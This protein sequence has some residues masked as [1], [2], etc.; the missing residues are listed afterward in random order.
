[1]VN[2]YRPGDRGQGQLTLVRPITI[3]SAAAR[4][5]AKYQP[6]TVKCRDS[7]YLPRF[8]APLWDAGMAALQ[9]LPLCTVDSVRTE[10]TV[11]GKGAG[12]VQETFPL[13]NASIEGPRLSGTMH[14]K[15]YFD[16]MATPGGIGILRVRAMIETNDGAS[17][18]V[19]YEARGDITQ[20]T[21]DVS[22]YSAPVFSTASPAYLWLNLVQAV[23]RGTVTA[24][25]FHWDWYEVVEVPS[26]R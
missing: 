13:L 22:G 12:V 14:G 1:M 8:G 15:T 4:A 26:R 6:R 25:R 3:R 2:E 21:D 23:G 5:K 24:E 10:P 11:V 18:Q 17:I 19:R 9:L 16:W 7:Q 20:G